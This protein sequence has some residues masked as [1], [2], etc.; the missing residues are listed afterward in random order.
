MAL[1]K[2]H[3]IMGGLFIA[4]VAMQSI[5]L[6]TNLHN[7]DCPI[8][9]Q[10]YLMTSLLAAMLLHMLLL[11]MMFHMFISANFRYNCKPY[12]FI[13]LFSFHLLAPM[14]SPAIVVAIIYDKKC[15]PSLT[16][17]DRVAIYIMS[18]VLSLISLLYCL[19]FLFV[20]YKEGWINTWWGHWKRRRSYFAHA[21]EVK[22]ASEWLAEAHRA[23]IAPAEMVKVETLSNVFLEHITNLYT[24][25][26]PLNEFYVYQAEE[27]LMTY[28]H[29]KIAPISW[30]MNSSLYSCGVCEQQLLCGDYYIQVPECDHYFH[31]ACLIPTMRTQK[32][33]HLCPVCVMNPLHATTRSALKNQLLT[34]TAKNI[35]SDRNEVRTGG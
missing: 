5:N 27:I 23:G 17:W 21:K 6:S 26:R 35:I 13:T 25:Y 34:L 24:R 8:V 33:N 14:F 22:A 32:R 20:V 18:S 12:Q 9:P 2:E 7:P 3:Y 1:K 30:K 11:E 10:Y 31:A 19:L 28:F 16:T 15:R 29:V 4:L